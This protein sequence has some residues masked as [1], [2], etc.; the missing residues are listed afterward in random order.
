MTAPGPACGPML[1]GQQQLIVMLSRIAK[2]MAD[3]AEEIIRKIGG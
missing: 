2:S 3:T 1:Q